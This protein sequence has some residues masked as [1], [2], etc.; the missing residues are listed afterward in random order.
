MTKKRHVH[1]VGV[2]LRYLRRLSHPA[3]IIGSLVLIL[4]LNLAFLPLH[5]KAAT[6]D[7]ILF[8]DP[9][10]GS[11]PSGWCN[12]S[13]YYGYFPRGASVA[14][15]TAD[16]AT[17][18]T[19]PTPS[20]P[21]TP[22]TGNIT[23]SASSG[24]AIAGNT[25]SGGT[26]LA[27]SNHTSS[28][29]AA[30]YTSDDNGDAASNPDLPAYRSLQLMEYGT[31][32]GSGGCNGNGVPN[33][34]PAKAIAMF[35]IALPSS[36]WTRV[37]AQDGRMIRIDSTTTMGGGDTE[38]NDITI[39]GISSSAGDRQAAPFL[40]NS[41]SIVPNHTHAP[42]SSLTCTSGCAATGSVTCP[43]KGS[44]GTTGTSTSTFTCTVA[45]A[46]VDP[47]YVQPLLGM[48]NVTTPAIAVDMVAMFD[49][50]PGVGWT[51]L[52][53]GGNTYDGQFIRPNSTPNFTSQ[54]KATRPAMVLTGTSGN[55]IGGAVSTLTLGGGASPQNHTH[56]ITV[57]TG[58]T[59]SSNIPPY[60]NVILAEKVSFILKHYEWYAV[61]SPDSQDVTD[62]WPSGS[63]LNIA[64]D[65]TLPAIP[66]PFRPPDAATG[67]MLRLRVQIQVGA[68]ALGVGGT[69][70]KLQY[71][72]TGYVDCIKGSWTDVAN[73]GTGG[74]WTYGTSATVSDSTHL[75]NSRLS[76]LSTYP[77]VFADS[78]TGGIVW[79]AA[80]TGTTI[81]YD[82][83]IM[84]NA[85]DSGTHYVFRPV[86]GNGQ[87]LGEYSSEKLSSSVCPSVV[88]RPGTNQLLR[89]G[90][91]FL[92]NPN[93][94]PGGNSEPKQGFLWAD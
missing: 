39:S 80:A 84:N 17:G 86:E 82:W 19:H 3:K 53:E 28:G 12:L 91:F 93:T 2:V 49:D 38:S 56:T 11:V 58:T 51:L 37:S 68:Q 34:I 24:T 20:R 13:R 31:S 10:N 36:D 87:P 25:N 1:A 41:N 67:T 85:A 4:V 35:N 33:N 81:E 63:G 92:T 16:W 78:Q 90:E 70:F 44:A 64:Q 21:Y 22:T 32:D 27:D 5:A 40:L 30:S 88:T 61:P 7:M 76:P 18:V 73:Y 60:F 75:S 46:N 47:P 74:P 54:G 48:A 59:A 42:P 77:Q 43:L 45:G 23:V 65:T 50:N 29:V 6:G 72:E 62:P 52:S 57:T 9:A 14:A 26:R 15:T 89:H 79:Q 83:L 69:S 71:A 94:E 55:A 8:W 66:A